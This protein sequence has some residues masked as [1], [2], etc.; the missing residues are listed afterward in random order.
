MKECNKT[1]SGIGGV[2]VGEA[3]SIFEL[4][5]E[6]SSFSVVACMDD[7]RS[8]REPDMPPGGQIMLKAMY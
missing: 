2:G 7:I 6:G 1:R 3:R 8:Q 4:F 5:P